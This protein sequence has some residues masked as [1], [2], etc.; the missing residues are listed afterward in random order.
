MQ[1]SIILHTRVFCLIFDLKDYL[2]CQVW[3][4]LPFEM[5]TIQLVVLTDIILRKYELNLVGSER[6][7]VIN[8]VVN[9]VFSYKAV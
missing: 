2:V 6:Y 1:A 8:N 3:I 5:F 4:L 7:I 9:T